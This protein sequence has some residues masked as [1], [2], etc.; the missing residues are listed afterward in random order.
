MTSA[1]EPP[2][3]G[4]R[5][6]LVTYEFPGGPSLER[7][8]E[9]LLVQYPVIAVRTLQMTYPGKRL[10][11][12]QVNRGGMQS[13][14]CAFLS[15]VSFSVGGDDQQKCYSFHC[16]VGAVDSQC[17]SCTLCLNACALLVHLREEKENQVGNFHD[18]K[19]IR[20][21]CV[22]QKPLGN[23]GAGVSTL[24]SPTDCPMRLCLSL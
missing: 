11:V 3:F 13:L 18:T 19:F 7:R 21:S 5:C 20:E 17:A 24:T 10:P 12:R 15:S 6:R 1:A 22:T 23:F 14:C 4:A 9:H 16:N 8:N 2:T